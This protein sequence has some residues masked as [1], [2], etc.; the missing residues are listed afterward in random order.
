M[1]SVVYLKHCQT[2]TMKPLF[3]HKQQNAVYTSDFT[4]NFLGIFRTNVL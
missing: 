2:S 3:L 4:K 1:F